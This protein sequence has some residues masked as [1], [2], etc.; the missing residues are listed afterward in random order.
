MPD[1]R[2]VMTYVSSYYHCFS[3]AQKVCLFTNDH[4]EHT[5]YLLFTFFN[6][7]NAKK[8]QKKNPAEK[9][10]VKYTGK[11]QIMRLKQLNKFHWS[12]RSI[13]LLY[14]RMQLYYNLQ[15]VL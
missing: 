7:K 4:T 14:H 11:S 13:Y 6:D 10:N 2:A 8:M 9:L 12:I 15:F 5:F 3:G 1:E